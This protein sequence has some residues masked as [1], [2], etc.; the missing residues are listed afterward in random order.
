M[1]LV[2]S[3]HFHFQG[4]KQKRALRKGKMG[5]QCQKQPGMQDISLQ[6][7]LLKGYRVHVQDKQKQGFVFTFSV[8]NPNKQDKVRKK[9]KYAN[10]I[11]PRSFLPI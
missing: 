1:N 6:H 10:A 9:L 4:G 11:N 8:E 3:D 7:V 5:Q 2:L